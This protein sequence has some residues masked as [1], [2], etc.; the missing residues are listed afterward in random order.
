[1]DELQGKMG[2]LGISQ[3]KWKQKCHEQKRELAECKAKLE[4]LT[5]KYDLVC[6]S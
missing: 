4:T 2:E 3:D 5:Q 1:M 6:Q